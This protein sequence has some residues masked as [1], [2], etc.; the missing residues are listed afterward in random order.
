MNLELAIP[1]IQ[2]MASR[3]SSCHRLYNIQKS[4]G[5]RQ[6]PRPTPF[7]ASGFIDNNTQSGRGRENG[8]A[9]EQSNLSF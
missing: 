6:G 3:A 4:V 1:K 9:R 2:S 8:E 5:T 7:N